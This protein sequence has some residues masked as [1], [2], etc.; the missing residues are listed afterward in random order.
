VGT[1]ENAIRLALLQVS[2]IVFAVLTSAA[3]LRLIENSIIPLS[4][5]VTIFMTQHGYL[6]LLLPLGWTW[7][8]VHRRSRD[9]GSNTERPGVFLAGVLLLVGLCWLAVAAI[10][11]PWQILNTLGSVLTAPPPAF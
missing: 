10:M 8:M 11:E 9:A 1:K 2:V 4:P 6:L 3:C 5:T 7:L